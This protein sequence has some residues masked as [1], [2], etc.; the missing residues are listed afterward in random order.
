MDSG[1]SFREYS[2][3]LSI[4]GSYPSSDSGVV[5]TGGAGNG[6]FRFVGD[7]GESID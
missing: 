7:L 5:A 1:T 4:D 6:L 3:L 2:L